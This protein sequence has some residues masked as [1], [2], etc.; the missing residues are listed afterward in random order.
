MCFLSY[1]SLVQANSPR[2]WAFVIAIY[3]VSIV[4]YCLLWNAYNHVSDLRAAALESPEVKA[5]QFAIVVR[6]IPPPPD[7]QTR[8]EQVDSYFKAIYPET[9]YRS[10]VV[11]NNKKVN[12][13]NGFF[14]FDGYLGNFY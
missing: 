10:M 3:L 1:F 2:L 5:E 4:A 6:D 12:C 8:K 14:C 11:T 7:G 13:V 9:F